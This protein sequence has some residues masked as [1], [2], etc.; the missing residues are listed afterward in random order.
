MSK[1]INEKTNTISVWTNPTKEI[2]DKFSCDQK[3]M[4]NHFI[5]E[6]EKSIDGKKSTKRFE[7]SRIFCGNKILEETNSFK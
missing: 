7:I 6:F 3:I 5:S 4:V 1:F 2:S